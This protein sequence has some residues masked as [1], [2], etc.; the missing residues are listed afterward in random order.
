LNNYI[1]KNNAALFLVTHDLEIAKKAQKLYL[2]EG[3]RLNIR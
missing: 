2:L 3:K 1:R